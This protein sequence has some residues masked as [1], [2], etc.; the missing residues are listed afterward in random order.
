M[1][2]LVA[3]LIGAALTLLVLA[4]VAVVVWGVRRRGAAAQD[5]GPQAH[6]LVTTLIDRVPVGIVIV[7]PHDELLAHNDAATRAAIVKGTRLGFGTLLECVRAVRKDGTAF[8]G[9]LSREPVPG[10]P[11]LSL[12][13]HI[14][15]LEPEQV[16][17]VGYDDAQS[18]RVEAVRRDFVANVSHELKTPIGAIGVLAEAVEAAKDDPEAVAR[19]S[20]RLQRET[21]RLSEL[22]TQIIN[23]SRLQSVDPEQEHEP[24]VLTEVVDDAVR[25]CREQAD[26]RRVQIILGHMSDVEVMGD[27]WQL[28][29]AVT[30]LIQNAIN[31]SDEGARVAISIAQVRGE[32]G[33]AVELKVSDNGIGI[34]AED[35]ER[36]FER[37]YRVDYGRSRSTGGTGLG[38]SIV[39]HIMLAHHGNIQVWS[40]LGQGSTF[41]L[42]FPAM[43]VSQEGEKTKP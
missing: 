25:N 42:H 16:L 19:F 18:R 4:L 32:D 38:L 11:P 24:V 17:V 3:A 9:A 37:F 7:G 43:N 23:L 31:Y 10:A 35:Q 26:N 27:Q 2:T 41:T 33:P 29:D 6:P 1:P 28:T 12:R 39:R 5:V 21:S 30:N 36:I 14:S 34:S 8:D 13:V 20:G 40:T 15:M 22:V